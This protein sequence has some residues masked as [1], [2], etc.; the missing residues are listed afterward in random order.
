[1]LAKLSL[2]VVLLAGVSLIAMDAQQPERNAA[3]QAEAAKVPP[4]PAFAQWVNKQVA[5]AAAMAGPNAPKTA[6]NAGGT[7][8]RSV[9]F[10]FP[11]ADHAFP[12]GD[13]V[14][15]VNNNC[16]AC[17][18]PGMILTQPKLTPAAWTGEVQKMQHTYQAP[19]ADADVPAIVAYLAT[20]PRPGQESKTE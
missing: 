16:T 20:L 11:A 13:G 10:E 2:V 19:V 12:P 7:A 5:A 14:E 4:T 6:V 15:L 18:S 3:A 17:H 1:M 9:G 8:I